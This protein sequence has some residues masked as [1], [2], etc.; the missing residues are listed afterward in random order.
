MKLDDVKKLEIGDLITFCEGKRNPELGLVVGRTEGKVKIEWI[1][2]ERPYV[3]NYPYREPNTS[4]FW[5]TIEK[6]S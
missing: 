4:Y 6:V 2:E 3:G 1:E 5:D